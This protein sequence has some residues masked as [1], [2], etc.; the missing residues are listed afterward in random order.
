MPNIKTKV[1]FCETAE[2]AE[3]LREAIEANRGRPGATMP[4]M[5]AAQDI[6]GYLPEEV[7]IR[8]AEGLGLPLSEVYG[9]ASFYS[10]FTLNPRGK[11]RVSVCL[12]T[13]CY[14]KGSQ[15]VLDKVCE[16]LGCEEGSI[17]P[18]GKFSVDATRC[19]GCCGLA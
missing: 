14:V 16:T 2:Q 5:Q 7:Q 12:G 15:E 3:A 9:I 17:T 11:Y 13:A 4:V 10:Q 1:P 6:Y 19:L 8:I 18:D